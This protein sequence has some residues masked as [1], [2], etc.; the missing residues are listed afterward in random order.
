MPS[1][2]YA[3]RGRNGKV[4]K[5]KLDAAS[6]SELKEKLK[7]RGLTLDP[8]SIKEKGVG[9]VKKLTGKKVKSKELLIFTR[10]LAVMVNTGLPLLQ[11]LDILAEQSESEH[12]SVIIGDVA[13]S[14]EGGETFSDALLAYP[15]VFPELYVSMVRSGEA[16]GE[17]D[18]VLV[19]LADYLE[20]SA[21]LR[22]RVKGA[23]TYPVA[24]FSI[25]LII[26]AGLIVFVVPQF[27]KIF[28]DM[29]APLPAPTQLLIAVSAWLRS[30]RILIVFGAIIA[31]IIGYR[32]YNATESGNY[33]IDAW[34]LRLPIFGLLMRKVATSRFTGTLATLTRSG[35]PILQ[36][37]D[38][39][40]AT[41]GNKV[42]A[43]VIREAADGV[44]NGESLADPLSRS[45]EYPPMVTR[46]IAVGEKTG[47]LEQML[48]K[49][50]EFYDQEV[51]AMVD[52]LTSL[53]EPILIVCMG[54]VVGGIIIAL[55]MPIMNLS[56][57]I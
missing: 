52:S 30:W 41:A 50:S 22:R 35:V 40:E 6:R 51:K 56:T 9:S 11:S 29:G 7:S 27:E 19:Q 32:V 13:N 28:S 12:F 21:E 45:G 48:F 39:V 46:M 47:A 25:I 31:M 42:F 18:G 54:V 8:S 55:F 14:V 37:L 43:K 38:I 36:A 17:L 15:R 57:I 2:S 16:S 5:G 1:Y 34:K 26:S 23:M 53:L 44:R 10:Q 33:N 20:A 24:A 3:A 4:Q 49:I